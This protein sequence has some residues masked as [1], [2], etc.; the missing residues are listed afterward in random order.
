M[1]LGNQIKALRRSRGI[2]Q[3][4]LAEK[5]GVSPQAVSKWERSAAMPDVQLLPELSACFGVTIDELFALSD[6]TRMTRIQNMLWD[7]RELSAED[8]EGAERFLLDRA[9]R[10]KEDHR[11]Y[12]LLAELHNHKAEEHRRLAEVYAKA[13]LTRNAECNSAYS[14]LVAAMGGRCPDWC[15]SNH[16][17]LTRWME[18]FLADHPDNVRAV[19]WLLDQLLDDQRFEEAETWCCRLARVDH[20]FRVPL[21][22]GMICWYRGDR[23]AA[24]DI[25]AQMQRDFPDDWLV[26]FSM[27]DMMARASRFD[28]AIAYYRQGMAVQP[29]P[30]YTDGI[31]SIAQICEITGDIP[32]AIAARQEE[33]GMLAED[34]GTTT[35]EMV[36]RQ[37]REI[38]RLEQLLR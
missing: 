13:A 38:R 29:R 26:C 36:D 25:W 11:P 6:E 4:T 37:H 22:R 1:E 12:E 30:R 20:T 2:T 15:V 5:L 10:E 21:Y 27:G 31:T 33:I 16:Y 32:G 23:A 3:E 34:W 24:T 9:G 28:E 14:E 35:G 8:V 17:R 18:D 19:L 7:Q